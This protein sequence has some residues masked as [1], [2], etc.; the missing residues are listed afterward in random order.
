MRTGCLNSIHA[1][2]VVVVLLSRSADAYDVRTHGFVTEQSFD[3]AHR[4]SL[5][6]MDVG[7]GIEDVFDRKTA[8]PA[9]LL[10]EFTNDGTARGWMAEGAIREDDFQEH[11]LLAPLECPQPRNPDSKIDRPKHHFFDVQRE[12]AGLALAL[13]LAA[14]DWALGLQGRGPSE[15]QNH[16]SLADARAYQ[17]RSLTENA[18]DERN[19]NTARLFRA[20]GQVTHLLQDMAQPQH[21]RN[22]PHLG[23]TNA[24]AKFVG[25]EKSWYEA[26]TEKRALN[27]RYR[28]R[29]DSNP[30]KL[31]GYDAV[32]LPTYR[33]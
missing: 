9:V 10:E 17:L 13:G 20:L 6:L 30:L 15:N 32:S 21:S 28:T 23:C 11:S 4:L 24:I 7:L 29:R 12:G 1:L 22:D 5:Y 27:H 33:D 25:G 3:A 16:F 14:P 2:A 19:R 8:T 31:A 26:Y 18:R